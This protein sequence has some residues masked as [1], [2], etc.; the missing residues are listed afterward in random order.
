MMRVIGHTVSIL[1]FLRLFHTTNAQVR[2][3]NGT[4]VAD[5][6]YPFQVGLVSSKEDEFPSC[7]GTLI[8]S[9][10]VL[11][12]AH[13]ET[14]F[15]Y[16]IIGRRDFSSSSKDY[17]KMKIKNFYVHPE[18]DAYTE[19]NDIMLI[20]LKKKSKYDTIKLDDGSNTLSEGDPLTVMGWGD[21]TEGGEQSHV[22]L[23]TQLNYVESSTCEETYE[24]LTDN[25]MC[26]GAEGKDSCQGDSGGPLIIKG[27][28]A[29]SD[30]QVG[31]VSYGSGC[32]RPGTPGVY[33]KVSQYTNWISKIIDYNSESGSEDEDD[34]QSE[35]RDDDDYG[36]QY[37]DDYYEIDA[38]F[39]IL[40]QFLPFLEA[41]LE[42]LMSLTGGGGGGGGGQGD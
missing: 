19:D 7:G 41:F 5:G 25:M 11:T 33:T 14:S 1:F 32:A 10:W 2:I 4:E 3:V 23:E 6:R 22:L 31:V 39:S 12:A 35:Y 16:A 28:Y 17:E 27:Y 37:R 36:P 15:S 20:R 42:F 9:K 24:D 29:S 40:Y 21:T 34:Y 30:I 38:F 18:Y 8:A 26:A 13:C